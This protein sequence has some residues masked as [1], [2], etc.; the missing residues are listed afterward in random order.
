MSVRAWSLWR[1]SS[2]LIMSQALVVV[3]PVFI[4]LQAVDIAAIIT[5]IVLARRYERMVWKTP[6]SRGHAGHV[7]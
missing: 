5:I 2:F 7:P 4:A 3:D 6:R 1:V